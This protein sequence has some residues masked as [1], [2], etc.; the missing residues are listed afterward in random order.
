MNYPD[1]ARPD[2]EDLLDRYDLR[3]EPEE[4]ARGKLRI[5]LG[6]APGVGKTWQMLLEGRRL[7]A[8][9]A[10]VV[11]GYVETHG[12][13]ETAAQIGDLE[14]VP[15]A[16]IDYRGKQLE[17]LDLGAVIARRP[18]I[19]LIDELAHTNVPGS[20]N[21][22]RWMDVEEIR[23]AGIDVITT[24]NIQH[25]ES[26][27]TTV[28]HITG[29]AVRETVPD[30]IVAEATEVQLV[31]LSVPALIERLKDGKVY[32]PERARQA[33][34]GFFRE[35]NLTALREL[36]L[37]HTAATVDDQLEDYMRD[38]EIDAV[39]GAAERILVLLDP[40]IPSDHAVRSAW[41]LAAGYRAELLALAI[42][43]PGDRA[44]R[45]RLAPAI[46][47]AE[48]L[49]ATVEIVESRDRLAVIAQITRDQNASTLVIPYRAGR[50]WRSRLE[51]STLDLLFDLLD[52]VDLHFVESHR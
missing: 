4:N 16:A 36:A 50:G 1:D 9:G 43:E 24:L 34:E 42:V 28:G 6:A 44:A 45:E 8:D 49:G 33:L 26:L 25:L 27:N 21:Q 48:D 13:Q 30:R 29:V 3:S 23:D 19:V 39:W 12:R 32:E 41:R 2:P 31:D 20:R 17:E 37:R 46:R 7:R 14:I 52:G 35:G 15:R 38:N 40:G 18:D 47:L 11:I 10:D 22:K 51:P 5:I